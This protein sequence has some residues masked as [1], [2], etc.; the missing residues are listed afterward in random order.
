MRLHLFALLFFLVQPCA[1]A[2]SVVGSDNSSPAFGGT[3]ASTKPSCPLGSPCSQNSSMS[4]DWADQMSNLDLMK[5]EMRKLHLSDKGIKVG[6]VDTGS[7]KSLGADDGKGR[8]EYSPPAG[9][10]DEKLNR[11]PL[12]TTLPELIKQLPRETLVKAWDDDAQHGTAVVE[13]IRRLSSG[14]IEMVSTAGRTA[15]KPGELNQLVEQACSKSRIVNVSWNDPRQGHTFKDCRSLQDRMLDKG[16]LVLIAAGNSGGTNKDCFTATGAIDRFGQLALLPGGKLSTKGD[17]YAPGERV[18]AKMTKRP[19]TYPQCDKE[20]YLV[21]GSSVADPQ[22]TAVAKN[23]ADILM[24]TGEYRDGLKPRNQ[25][26]LI[27][28]ILRE[29]AVNGRLDGYRAVKLAESCSRLDQVSACSQ[30][31]R[32]KAHQTWANM[33]TSTHNPGACS[34]KSECGSRMTCYKE[35]RRWLASQD[36]SSKIAQDAIKDMFVTAH[37]SGDYELAANWATQLK[38]PNKREIDSLLDWSEFRKRA[39]KPT[40][41]DIVVQYLTTL[42]GVTT[43]PADLETQILNVK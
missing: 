27:D 32:Y 13:M 6:V 11:L 14:G 18:P 1:W 40:N 9:T 37:N 19:A 8:I 39:E 38:S 26:L 22:T 43:V 34:A 4:R 10:N 36:P 5:E 30:N 15:L 42:L 33:Q 20:T 28:Q 21:S 3:L 24:Q 7:A 25:A 16:C 31:L 41:P 2:D 17:L 35:K 23:V 12:G 29:S